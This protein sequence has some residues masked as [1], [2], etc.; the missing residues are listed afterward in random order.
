MDGDAN[1]HWF[2]VDITYCKVIFHE[3]TDD[4][5]NTTKDDNWS[6]VDTACL[7]RFIE[8]SRE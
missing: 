3:T 1:E 8:A 5:C 4:D 2:R 6:Q 7:I